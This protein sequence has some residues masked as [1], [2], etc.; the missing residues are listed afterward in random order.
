MNAMA[1]EG[2]GE[3]AF[4]VNVAL[5]GL[6]VPALLS[7]A[8]ALV[9]GWLSKRSAAGRRPGWGLALAL[10][11]GYA[12]GHL[13]TRGLPPLPP[14][15][16]TDWLLPIAIVGLG[17]GLIDGFVKFPRLV[18]WVGGAALS[19][20]TVWLIA[21][22]MLQPGAEGG[23]GWGVLAGLACA[24]LLVWSALELLAERVPAPVLLLDMGAVTAVAGF[25]GA[26]TGSLIEGRLAGALGASIGGALAA[27][28]ILRGSSMA[29]GGL[30]VFALL[31]PAL[32]LDARLYAGLP[33]ACVV[34]LG[35]APL[36]LWAVRIP[37]VQRLRPWQAAL[38]GTIAILIPLVAASALAIAAAPAE[39]P[40][41]E[42]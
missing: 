7:L 14:L 12:A 17:A 41:E 25:A 34:L 39:T 20:L 3:S 27:T 24:V 1:A 31:L 4:L 16:T 9:T 8:I 10:G 19:A 40:A 5:F 23:F 6:A 38:V 15:E 11:V 36:G 21:R 29:R 22:P 13:A 35:L 18:R 37:L 33:G 30:P 32:L 42:M 2:G 26:W 28:A